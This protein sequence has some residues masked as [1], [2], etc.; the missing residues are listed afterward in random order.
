VNDDVSED[1]AK[2][3]DSDDLAKDSLIK[4]A[5]KKKATGKSK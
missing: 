2:G 3:K 4:T 5:K 1:E